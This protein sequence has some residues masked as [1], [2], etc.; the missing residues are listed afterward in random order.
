MS[1]Y[2]V[3]ISFF[4]FAAP[5]NVYGMIPSCWCLKGP[6]TYQELVDSYQFSQYTNCYL[7]GNNPSSDTCYDA[8]CPG[9]NWVKGHSYIDAFTKTISATDGDDCISKCSALGG[10]FNIANMQATCWDNGYDYGNYDDDD[11]SYGSCNIVTCPG[12]FDGHC[13][14]FQKKTDK[15]CDN[16]ASANICCAEDADECCEVDGGAIGG[17]I[18]GAAVFII[19]CFWYRRRRRDN[20]NGISVIECVEPVDIEGG[21]IT[22]Q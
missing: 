6:D 10:G 17:S 13:G 4:L 18:A 5:L 7:S 21:E 19:F 20:Y 11:N 16:D 2:I 22:K 9:G 8:I 3:Y 12:M 14:S 15:W 1:V